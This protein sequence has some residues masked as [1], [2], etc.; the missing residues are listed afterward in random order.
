MAADGSGQRQ[1]TRTPVDKVHAAWRPGSGEILYHTNG[2]ESFLLNPET[3]DER[4]IL[5]GLTV[6]DAAWSPEGQR[7]AYGLPPEDPVKGKTSLWVSGL[8]GADRRRVAGGDAADALAPAWVSDGR[9]LLY[10]QCLGTSHSDV[11]HDFFLRELEGES[12][13]RMLEGDDER[14]KFDQTLSKAGTLAY[15]SLRSGSFEIWTLRLEGGTPRQLTSFDSYAGSPSWTSDGHGL[16]FD[17]D[18]DGPLQIYQ[19]G[20]DGQ[21]LKR[22]TSGAAPSR[23]PVWGPVELRSEDGAPAPQAAMEAT[24]KKTAEPAGFEKAKPASPIALTWVS[25]DR[26]AFDPAKGERLTL[27]FRMTKPAQVTVRFLDPYGRAVR[28]FQQEASTAGE[29]H[30]VWDGKDDHGGLV[31]PEAYLYT[32]AARNA[33][34]DEATYD[35]RGRSG[36]ERV[37]PVQPTLDTK[38]GRIRYSLTQ[39]S[40]VRLIVS[41]TDTTW[42]IRT[43]LDWVPREAGKHEEAWDGWDDGHVVKGLNAP[44]LTPL[45][46]MFALPREA[47][48]VKG[49]EKAQGASRAAVASSEAPPNPPSRLSDQPLYFHAQHPRTRCY[50]PQIRLSLLDGGEGAKRALPR[51]TRR[52]ALRLDIAPAQRPG[53]TRPIPRASVF[54][55]VDGVMVERYLVG[56][57]PFQWIL[58]PVKM[59]SGEH[60]V[61]GL[62]AWREDHFGIAH[63]RVRTE[64]GGGQ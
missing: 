24:T 41:R 6:T 7:L 1:L 12:P 56:Y 8:D 37:W 10:R 39:P 15:S 50:D 18:K 47:V 28:T 55:Y 46:Y 27:R 21:G 31:P 52:T 9:S 30:V 51:I 20:P 13:P 4:R 17:G 49:D 33:A 40:R 32:L 29:Q 22:L 58:D 62:L 43:L 64:G 25:T 2:G 11:R 48:I 14:L 36:G 42:P 60:V 59:A 63:L 19:V 23:K 35:M 38:T 34:R 44:S 3:G 16:A 5:D 57:V 54:I 61:T 45:F 53:V 26:S